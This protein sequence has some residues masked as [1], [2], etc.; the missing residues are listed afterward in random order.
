MLYNKTVNKTKEHLRYRVFA[1][2]TDQLGDE[3]IGAR[4]WELWREL[5]R[6]MLFI[7]SRIED[8]QIGLFRRRR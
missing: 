5:E 8:G 2:V 1:S 3:L 6:Q 7:N 4:W